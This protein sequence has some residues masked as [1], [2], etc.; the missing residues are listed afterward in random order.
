MTVK[1]EVKIEEEVVEEV[2]EGK[3]EAPNDFQKSGKLAASA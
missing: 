1:K 3:P 2:I